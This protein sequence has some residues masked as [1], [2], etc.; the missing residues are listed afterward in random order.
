[1]VIRY[2]PHDMSAVRVATAGSITPILTPDAIAVTYQF[3]QEV[4]WLINQIASRC[5]LVVHAHE[6]RAIDPKIVQEAVAHSLRI[7]VEP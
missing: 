2:N 3:C 6:A 5:L 1:M 4:P 7:S